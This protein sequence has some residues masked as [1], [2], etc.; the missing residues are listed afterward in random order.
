MS[1]NELIRIHFNSFWQNEKYAISYMSVSQSYPVH[2]IKQNPY[3]VV[4]EYVYRVILALYVQCTYC[5][6]L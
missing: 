3:V 5:T 6:H 2:F 1:V 4:R